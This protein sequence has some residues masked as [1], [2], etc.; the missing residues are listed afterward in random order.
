MNVG[1]RPRNAEYVAHISG[2]VGGC[3]GLCAVCRQC[4]GY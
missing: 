1:I 2:A 3:W 4:E